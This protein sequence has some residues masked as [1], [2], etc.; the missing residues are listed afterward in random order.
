MIHRKFSIL[1][2]PL[3]IK[4]R[5]FLPDQRAPH[6]IICVCHGIPS[7]NPP[8]PYDR[9]YPGLAEEICAHDLG[10]LIFNFRG[11]G[12]SG[13][14]IDMRGWTQDLS[15]II[16][17]MITLEAIDPSRIALLGFS[18]GAAVSIC[19]AAEDHRISCVAAC[20]CP[21]DFFRIANDDDAAFWVDHF[22][23]IGAIRDTHFPGSVQAWARDFTSVRPI[24][25]IDRV[26]PKPLL[27]V[28]SNDDKTVPISH[29]HCLYEKAG[30]PKERVIL[31]GAGHG[32]R[33]DK[34]AMDMVIEWLKARLL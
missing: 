9:G 12:L 13:G 27:L 17:Y 20:A 4:G 5:I 11:T 21:T 10:V 19:A 2:S 1:V 30:Q 16:D 18:G 33:H 32:L 7:G 29:M 26:S 23:K 31:D 8:D 28:H 22:R 14:N 3:D 24:D 6:P 15:A 34:K 25:C